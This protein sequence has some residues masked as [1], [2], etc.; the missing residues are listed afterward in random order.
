VAEKVYVPRHRTQLQ[1][2]VTGSFDCGVRTCQELI[3]FQTHGKR[4]PGVDQVRRQ[5]GRPGAQPTNVFNADALFDA[6]GLRYARI[7]GGDFSDLVGAL[8][9]GKAA[10]ICVAYGVVTDL[11]PEK[12]GSSSFRG[13]HS[14][15]VQ[16]LRRNRRGR[17]VV[18]SLDSLFDGRRRGVPDGPKWVLLETYRRACQAFAGRSG[19]WWGGIVPPFRGQVSGPGEDGGWHEPEEPD[20]DEIAPIDPDAEPVEGDT[21][22]VGSTGEDL[23]DRDVDDDDDDDDDLEPVPEDEDED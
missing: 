17:R 4:N 11:Q 19:L 10:Q 3:D 7:V 15:Y 14:I 22:P 21:L 20:V 5:M 18:L 2:P 13:G 1:R 9:V 12:S 8:K 23:E 6:Q 16:K